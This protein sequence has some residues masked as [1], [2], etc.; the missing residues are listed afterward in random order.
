MEKSGIASKRTIVKVIDKL[1]FFK[2][3]GEVKPLI[4]Y[5][6]GRVGHDF[7]NSKFGLN[8][9]VEIENPV[10]KSKPASLQKVKW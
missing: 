1:L 10:A 2:H 5:K 6:S 4:T 9:E 3:E 8:R 7:E